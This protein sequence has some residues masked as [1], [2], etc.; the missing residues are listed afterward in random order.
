MTIQC[1]KKLQQIIDKYLLR[2]GEGHIQTSWIIQET[3]PL[4]FIG[5][6]T[7]QDDKVFLSTLERI[8][9]GYFYLLQN[10]K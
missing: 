4:M 6:D 7:R 10:K 1:Q 2:P 5:S 8:N 9:T 3:Y